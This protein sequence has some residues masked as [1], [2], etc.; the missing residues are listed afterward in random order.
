MTTVCAGTGRRRLLRISTDNPKRLPFPGIPF[1][2]PVMHRVARSCALL[3]AL[4]APL[5]AQS[6]SQREALARWRDSLEAATTRTALD[7]LSPRTGDGDK[8]L[9]QLRRALL[10]ARRGDLGNDRQAFEKALFDLDQSSARHRD[11]PW[12]E[13]AL[14]ATF[15]EFAKRDFPP[16]AS[17]GQ[18][19]GE[20]QLDAAWRHLRD[21]LDRDPTMPEARALAL[22]LLVPAGD[23]TLPGVQQQILDHLM[24]VPAPEADAW[25]VFGRALRGRGALDSARA[26]F[27]RS[28]GAGGDASRLS[29]EGARTLAA[30]DDTL[31]AAA[32]YWA[33]ARH[34]TAIGRAAYRLDLEWIAVDDS[35]H[36]FEAATGDSLAPWLERFWAERDARSAKS[37]DGRLIEHLRRWNV[38]FTRYRVAIP[39]RRTMFKR[40]EVGFEGRDLCVAGNGK[41][42]EQLARTPP[43][44]PDDLRW[45]EA[46]LDHRGLIYLRHGAPITGLHLTGVTGSTPMRTT[47]GSD[48][49]SADPSGD[50]ALA[51]SRASVEVWVYWMDGDWRVLFFRGSKA[52]GTYAATTLTSY[53]PL[54]YVD[55]WLQVGAKIPQYAKAASSMQHPS[56]VVPMS[57]M[58]GIGQAIDKSRGDATLGISTDSDTP[59]IL[60]PWNAVLDIFALGSGREESGRALLTFAIPMTKLRT[61]PR[62]SG[63]VGIDIA[64]RLSAFER[65]T[66]RMIQLDTVRHF[67]VNDAAR[68]GQYLSGYFELPLEPGQWNVSILARQRNDSSGAFAEVRGQVVPVGDRLALSDI[69]TGAENGRPLLA[70][71]AGPLPLNALGAWRRDVP[72]ELYFEVHG[73]AAGAPFETTIELRPIERGNRQSVTLRTTERAT[74]STTPM[75]RTVGLDRL[76]PGRYRLTVTVA[77]GGITARQERDLL[78]APPK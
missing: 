66:G 73:L 45:R 12:P 21:A 53:L 54:S 55:E 3:L 71:L 74:G 9:R 22:R 34:A 32:L 38:A 48:D 41:F 75:R 42:Y 27:E 47:G 20:G 14:A 28:L 69:V 25:L 13:F 50:A 19:D 18:R 16:L 40:V 65:A 4:V 43:H 52:Y 7:A 2:G 37:P 63:R 44:D 76:P 5:A 35:L 29:L 49:A 60:R 11:W 64:F 77:A 36:G 57:C 10:N 39:W 23:R 8:A 58:P 1:P 46:L 26:A 33:G 24:R 62:D 31:G 51:E 61:T 70:T 6:P 67:A 17:D 72:A 15:R 68:P 30:L 56:R 59:P 78:V